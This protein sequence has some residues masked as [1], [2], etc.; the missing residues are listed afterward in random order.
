[1][2]E[3]VPTISGNPY[4]DENSGE[5]TSPEDASQTNG[6][7]L[8]EKQK[9]IVER[10][11]KFLGRNKGIEVV[12][13]FNFQKNVE[14]MNDDEINKETIYLDNQL[15]EKYN[16][17]FN[18]IKDKKIKLVNLRQM[19]R[20]SEEFPIR[21]DILL[22]ESGKIDLEMNGKLKTTWGYC[23]TRMMFETSG[24]KFVKISLSTK[25]FQEDYDSLK[26]DTQRAIKTG[27]WTKVSDNDIL[28]MTLTHEY[29]HLLSYS[30]TSSLFNTPQEKDSI[31]INI[32]TSINK[33]IDF[34]KHQLILAYFRKK[35]DE[36]FEK[37][38]PGKKVQEQISGYGKTNINEWF[39]E[40]FLG[41]FSG[42]SNE[43]QKIFMETL[44]KY[45]KENRI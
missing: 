43:Y 3:K 45:I 7:E 42:E 15:Q 22:N 29:G 27:F 36:A 2:A 34:I 38:Y 6:D 20:L 12:S 4:H 1:M 17:N 8:N 10:I 30:L 19:K 26:K 31:P 24:I 5:F 18:K 35:V 37:R 14:D 13:D 39:A 44:K 16:Y 25:V 23:R 33:N 28:S 32:T 40:T 41:G 11:K 21:N 9:R